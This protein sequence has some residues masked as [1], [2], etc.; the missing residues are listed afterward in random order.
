MTLQLRA[1]RASSGDA[2]YGA[3]GSVS[4]QLLNAQLDGKSVQLM[5]LPQ[6]GAL[7]GPVS[8]VLLLQPG[9]GVAAVENGQLI[10]GRVFNLQLDIEP[11]LSISDVRTGSRETSEA[12][13]TLELVE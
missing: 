3:R 2:R 13:L 5:M 10:Q 9:Q 6:D 4:L 8:S 1:E 11:I 7:S 12:N